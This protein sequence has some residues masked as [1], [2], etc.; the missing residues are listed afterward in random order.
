MFRAIAILILL[1]SSILIAPAISADEPSVAVRLERIA[2]VKNVGIEEWRY[3]EGDVNGAE[4]PGFDDSSWK[5]GT[6]DY[7]WGDGPVAW[8]RKTVVIP[9][10][11]ETIGTVAMKVVLQLGVDD[12]GEVFVNGVLRR[13]FNWDNCNVVLSEN[14]KPGETFNIAVKMLNTGGPGRMLLANLELYQL[15]A[16]DARRLSEDY[17]TSAAILG[18]VDAA[19]RP[20]YENAMAEC[21]KAIDFAAHDRDDSQAF[22]ASLR[23]AEAALKPFSDIADQ[24]TCHLI[25]HAHIDMNW[26]WLWPETVQVCQ[27]TFTSVTNLMEEYP[28]FKFSQSQPPTYVAVQDSKPKLFAKIKERIKDGRWEITGGTWVEGDMNM[29]SGESIV[30]QIMYA[31]RYFRETF[32]KEPEVCWEP[33]TFGHAWTVPQIL[34]KSGLKYYVFVRCGVGK[35]MFWWQSPDGSRVLAFNA[36][37]FN[38][39]LVGRITDHTLRWSKQ[40]GIRDCPMIYGVGDH[41]GGPT[42]ADIEA[43]ANLNKQTVAPKV[44]FSSIHEFFRTALKQKQ[45]FPVVNGE[46]NFTF[47]GCYTTHA[48]AK[49]MNRKSENLLPAAE[50][51]CAIANQMG[52]S[53]PSSDFRDSWHKACFNQFHDIFDGSAIHGSYDYSRELFEKLKKQASGELQ[54]SL[55]HIAGRIDTRGKGTPIVVFNPLAWTRT[56]VV[57]VAS[58][59]GGKD[60]DVHVVDSHGRKFPAQRIGSDVVFT[61][62]DVPSLGYAVYW[63]RSGPARARSESYARAKSGPSVCR[64]ENEFLAVEVSRTTGTIVSVYD[65]R[66]RREVVT[67]GRS[68]SLLQALSEAPIG[69]SAWDMGE[70]KSTVSLARGRDIEV[71]QQGPVCSSIRTDHWYRESGFAQ[72]IKLYAGVPRIDIHLTADWQEV[73]TPQKGS[74]TLKTSF[75]VDVKDG[76]ATFE[77]PFGSIERK[78]DGSEVP[79]QKWIDLSNGSYGVSLLN[80]CKYGHDVKDNTMRLTLL[81]SPYDPD[82]R[83]DVGMHDVT[84]SIYP[85]AGDWRQAGTVRRS[86]ELNNPLIAIAASVHK[87]K[88]PSEKSFVSVDSANIIVTAFKKAE[89]GKGFILRFYE[90]AGTPV[91]TRIQVAGGLKLWSEVSMDEKLGSG[92]ANL[93]GRNGI[94]VSVGKYEIKTLLLK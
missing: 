38:G 25:G 10:K 79:A 35:P 87:G 81:R 91:Q 89:D 74:T 57:E 21:A 60:T 86:Y 66:A 68:C 5:I 92:K 19:K 61:A 82:P 36:N 72:D 26:L 49:L 44:K 7:N 83:P 94:T 63:I 3:I 93:I 55:K 45:D 23:K 24:Y 90:S 30:R 20:I 84:Y 40:V 17:R 71:L 4:K 9:G 54:G 16:D 11:A 76:K 88:L 28:E 29:A 47:R 42:R 43:A 6:P 69:M 53:Y 67:K 27:N 15:M 65:K 32:G 48:D 18:T 75:T 22:L 8:A 31:K 41:G 80:D 77:I 70:I 62:R 85:H 52:R 78:A 34:K 2:R 1:N 56:D 14:A 12:D 59:L 46:L 39:S 64:I 58:P 37:T 13:K 51:F 33:D 50:A 73:G